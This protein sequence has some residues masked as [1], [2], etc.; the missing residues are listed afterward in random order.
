[1]PFR[2]ITP[3]QAQPQENMD[4]A[5]VSNISE[6]LVGKIAKGNIDFLRGI[7]K[8]I[9][10]TGVGAVG[11]TERGLKAVGRSATRLLSTD[12][13]KEERLIKRFGFDSPPDIPAKERYGVAD[14]LEATTSP[15]K[16]GKFVGEVLATAPLLE[17]GIGK[18]AAKTVT[19]GVTKFAPKAIKSG[20]LDALSRM[21]VKKGGEKL[22]KVSEVFLRSAPDT[23]TLEAI[24]EDKL[25]DASDYTVGFLIDTILPLG[26]KA[27]NWLAPELFRMGVNPSSPDWRD[28]KEKAGEAVGKY[29]GTKEMIVNQT[30]DVIK[31]EGKA[32][33][34]ILGKRTEQFEP[35]NLVDKVIREAQ[36]EKAIDRATHD[37]M[38]DI[39]NNWVDELPDV[40]SAKELL[41]QKRLLAQKLA[42]TFEKGVA[43]DKDIAAKRQAWANLWVEIDKTL[44]ALDPEIKLRNR[45]MTVAYSIKD[46]LEKQ[47]KGIP[48]QLD[49]FH[50][51]SKF[52]LA[53][54]VTTALA[55]VAK[56]VGKV[57]EKSRVPARV[58][59]GESDSE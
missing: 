1:M 7:P 16:A 6:S 9:R 59:E 20:T 3:P 39:A 10:E 34:E 23:L 29:M 43:M 55:P 53:T 50:L 51:L 22:S 25:P 42:K 2:E 52:P 12:D 46:P 21:G 27:F 56:G 47:L 40:L 54:P 15:E 38:L 48:F 57:L 5:S 28:V 49:L 11:A 45:K 4:N 13:A 35:I 30:E 41:E 31:K 18:L 8:G 36:A 26:G 19:T 37:T 24:I 44:D 14:Q 17:A 33:D 58:V 32:L